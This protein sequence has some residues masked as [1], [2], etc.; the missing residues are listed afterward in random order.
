[1]WFNR[2]SF[3]IIEGKFIKVCRWAVAAAGTQRR[4]REIEAEVESPGNKSAGQ[5]CQKLAEEK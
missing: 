5:R 1:M 3:L 4:L 2:D